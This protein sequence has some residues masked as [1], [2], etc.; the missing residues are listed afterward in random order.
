MANDHR[1]PTRSMATGRMSRDE[2]VTV[3]E[4]VGK[5]SEM[6]ELEHR[7][8]RFV[9]PTTAFFLVDYLASTSSPAPP[10]A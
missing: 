10:L 5:D 2:A 3:T 9:W 8:S 6:V 4:V 7:H 1:E